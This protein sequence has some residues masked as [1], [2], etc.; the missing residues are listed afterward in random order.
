MSINNKAVPRAFALLMSLAAIFPAPMAG[1]PEVQIELKRETRPEVAIAV[2]NF[3]LAEDSKDPAGTGEDGRN[4]LENDLK[5]S[6]IFLPINRAV[7]QE[8]EKKERDSSGVDY[9]AWSALG[10]QWVIKTEYGI[11]PASK[12]FTCVFRLYDAVNR[13]FLIGKR[14][15]GT[16]DF[17]RRTMH[18]F[19]DEVVAQLTGKRGVAETRIA[20]LSKEDGNKEIYTVDF[21]GFGLQKLTRDRSVALS[22]AWSPDGNYIVY[23]SYAEHNPDLVMIDGYGKGRRPILKLPGLNA[24]PSWSPD[25]SKIAL[26]LSKDQNSEIYVLE[27]NLRLTRLT[28]HFNIDTSPSWS[29]DGKQIVFT[30]DRSGTGSPQIYIMDSQLGDQ[31][32]VE[33]ISFDSSYNDNPAWSPDGDKIA[34]TARVGRKFRIKVYDIGTKK[35]DELSSEPG[36]HEGP[37]WSPDGRFIAYGRT[38]NGKMDIFI[39]RVGGE[40][41]RQLTFLTNG[42]SSPAWSPN[43]TQ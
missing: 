22:P 38:E 24:A 8:Q 42:A 21:D 28:R 40:K 6:E 33:R 11:N 5:L 9:A 13:K 12:N 32:K 25:G 19:A 36:S 30:S 1:Q 4:I 37:A 34:H 27:K 26:A 10:V 23:T 14:Y 18:R 43:P 16:Q 31:A 20:F 41:S 2:Q 35:A 7:F 3:K 39:K 17:L 15:T 29:P